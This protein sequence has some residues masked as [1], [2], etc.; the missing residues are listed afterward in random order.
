MTSFL[1]LDILL[2]TNELTRRTAVAFKQIICDGLVSLR[3]ADYSSHDRIL[4]SNS[5]NMWSLAENNHHD[6]QKLLK[7]C[8][9]QTS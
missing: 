7:P 2:E 8:Q 5:Q 6:W 3:F 4:L 9:N 1:W